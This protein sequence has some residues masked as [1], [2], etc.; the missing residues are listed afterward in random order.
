MGGQVRFGFAEAHADFN[1]TG[2]DTT[3]F[4]PLK[5]DGGSDKGLRNLHACCAHLLI[6]CITIGKSSYI[7]ILL[8]PMS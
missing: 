2:T 6:F 4:I 7:R 5:F 3:I 1:N 8:D